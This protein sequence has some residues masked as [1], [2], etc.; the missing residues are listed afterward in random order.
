MKACGQ[1][2]SSVSSGVG[3]RPRLDVDR[4]AL[5]V[6]CHPANYIVGEGLAF[7]CGAGVASLGVQAEAQMGPSASMRLQGW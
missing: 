1:N 4:P 2:R 7:A 5:V 6:V 3:G